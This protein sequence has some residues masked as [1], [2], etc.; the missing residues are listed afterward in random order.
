MSPKTIAAFACLKT[1]RHFIRMFWYS[2]EISVRNVQQIKSDRRNSQFL[3]G[4]RSNVLFTLQW[5]VCV[6]THTHI[7]THTPHTHTHTHTHTPHTNTHTHT[8]THT[9]HTHKHT[10]PHTHTHTHTHAHTS[11]ALQNKWKRSYFSDKPSCRVYM[12]PIFQNDAIR[13]CFFPQPPWH[14]RA[15]TCVIY[16]S[17]DKNQ[18]SIL[19]SQLEWSWSNGFVSRVGNGIDGYHLVQYVTGRWNDGLSLGFGEL[20]H[21]GIAF[22]FKES[23]TREFVVKIS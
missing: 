2:L 22:L 8:Y 18:W 10:P 12:R 13:C 15:T 9:P 11:P 14:N 20:K 4:Y 3:H 23:E 5:D 6:H 7:H 1:Q 17:I 21:G 19:A 16:T